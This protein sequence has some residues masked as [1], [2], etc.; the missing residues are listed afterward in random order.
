MLRKTFESAFKA[1]VVLEALKGEETLAELNSQYGVHDNMITR[2]KQELLAR[3]P[4]LFE[5]GKNRQSDGQGA[6]NDDLLKIIGE[7]SYPVRHL[8]PGR[9]HA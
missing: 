3:L 5:K 4:E 9:K 2:W 7:R 1:R 6:K 8:F